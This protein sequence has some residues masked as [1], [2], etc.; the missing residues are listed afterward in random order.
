MDKYTDYEFIVND[1]LKL[2]NIL[3]V[4]DINSDSYP[5]LIFSLRSKKNLTSTKL[6]I[7]LN[8]PSGIPA[9]KGRNFEE[10]NDHSLDIPNLVYSSF[11]DLDENGYYKY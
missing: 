10:K 4:G 9:G 11:F 6:V 1:Q 7:F 5:D 8:S 2:E 3:R